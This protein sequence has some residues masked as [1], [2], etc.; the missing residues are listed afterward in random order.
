[1]STTTKWTTNSVILYAADQGDWMVYPSGKIRCCRG[2]RSFC[3]RGVLPDAKHRLPGTDELAPGED[4][5]IALLVTLA[6]DNDYGD[7]STVAT[8]RRVRQDML[9]VFGLKEISQ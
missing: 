1:M 8:V 4:H 7:D 9:Q 3:P 5:E 6:A 2:G